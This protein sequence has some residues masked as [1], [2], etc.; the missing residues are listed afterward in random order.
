[1][2]GWNSCVAG[3]VGV[4][5][6]PPFRSQSAHPPPPATFLRGWPRAQGG[7]L[8]ELCL[9]DEWAITKV[10]SPARS[11]GCT[12]FWSVIHAPELP[13]GN[14]RLPRIARLQLALSSALSNFPHT[15]AGASKGPFDHLHRNPNPL[16]LC[17]S[18]ICPKT[19]P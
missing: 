10:E 3:A 8:R 5:P 6:R 18:R 2:W 14:G 13:L 1:M 19:S 15:L 17:F 7:L 11:P 12:S 9:G 16:K 4:L